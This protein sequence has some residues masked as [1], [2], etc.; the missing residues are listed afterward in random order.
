M[1]FITIDFIY[2]RLM[3]HYLD[4]VTFRTRIHLNV[5][6]I[7]DNVNIIKLIREE[8]YDFGLGLDG[9]VEMNF[10]SAALIF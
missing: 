10:H 5:T 6:S 3:N 4:R 7:S 1:V 2:K 9:L 8:V